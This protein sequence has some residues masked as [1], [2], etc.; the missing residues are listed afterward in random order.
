M[1][2]KL[3]LNAAIVFALSIVFYAS[4]M[5]AKHDPALSKVIPFGEDP[6]DAVGSLGVVVG[7]IIAGIALVRAFRPYRQQPA[8]EAQR[9]F[10]AR[11]ETA[12]VLMVLITLLSDAVAMARHPSQWIDAPSRNTLLALLGGLAVV[13]VA[14]QGLIYGSVGARPRGGSAAALRAAI[15][16]ALAIVVLAIY[17]EQW[18]RGIATHLFTV[19]VGDVLLFALARLLLIALLPLEQPALP[20]DTALAK[21]GSRGTRRRWGVVLLAG[22]LFGIFAFVG[23]MSEGGGP[24]PILRLILVAAVFIVLAIAGFL[25][26]YA[27]LGKPLGFGRRA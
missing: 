20:I 6:Y 17:P 27:F 26:A 24:A 15:G 3:R 22:V 10:L 19:V 5:F 8:T 25:I 11:T 14:M 16:V 7:I 23:E 4:F 18:I 12:V 2:A 9:L 21:E 1:P 13:A